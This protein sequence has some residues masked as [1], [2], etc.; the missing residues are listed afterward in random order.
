MYNRQFGR[1]LIRTIGGKLNILEDKAALIFVLLTDYEI[2]RVVRHPNVSPI[3]ELIPGGAL[4][5][6]LSTREKPDPLHRA[7]LAPRKFF[8]TQFISISCNTD[9]EPNVQVRS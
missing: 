1:K 5:D 4:H 2:K 3:L 7:E 9:N 6:P 8:G